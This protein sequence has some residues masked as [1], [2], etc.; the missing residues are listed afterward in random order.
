MTNILVSG[1]INLETTLKVER[2]PIDYSP[3][4]YPFFGVRS[5][6]S[7]VGFNLAKALT[8]LGDRVDFLSIVGEDEAGKLV[9]SAL[10]QLPVDDRYIDHRAAQTAQS[11]ILYDETGRRAINV[12]LKDIQELSY[13]AERFEQALV[14]CRLAVLCN[15]NFSR[16]FLQRAR[17][18]GARVATDVHAISD[19]E[20]DYNRDF[21]AAAQVLFMSHENL[22]CSPEEWIRSAYNRYGS[23]IMVVGL[24]SQGAL[25]WVAKDRFL[26]RLPAVYTRPVVNTIGAGDALFACFLH[27]YAKN[28]DPY[29]A[30]QKAMTYASYKIGVTGAAEGLLREDELERI[31]AEH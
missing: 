20:D 31:C 22:P 7:G 1:L 25:L 19:L 12:D 27:Y 9:H 4:R 14:E 3:V 2:F 30:I 10:R 5:A 8:L 21:M 29:Q 15:I 23:E 17:Q 18:A 26:E 28:A 24:G 11:V 6:V 16:P 13:P